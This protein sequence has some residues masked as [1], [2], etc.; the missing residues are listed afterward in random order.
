MPVDNESL[1]SEISLLQMQRHK[2]Y[3]KLPLQANFYPLPATAF[4]Q[5]SKR[6]LTLHTAQPNGVAS[7]KQGMGFHSFYKL[8]D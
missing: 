7:L 8:S 2:T 4:I 5:D 1:I 6:R 3:D